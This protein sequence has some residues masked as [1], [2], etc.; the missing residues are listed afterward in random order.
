VE[1]NVKKKR[2][3]KTLPRFAVNPTIIFVH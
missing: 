3:I 1:K 2:L